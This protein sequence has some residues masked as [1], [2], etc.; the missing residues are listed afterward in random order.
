MI[1]IKELE[2]YKSMTMG[3]YWWRNRAIEELKRT[4]V[5]DF[6]K[7]E[8]QMGFRNLMLLLTAGGAESDN[9]KLDLVERGGWMSG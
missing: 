8:I 9:R 5:P 2:T 1:S 3:E 6:V 7:C 4:T